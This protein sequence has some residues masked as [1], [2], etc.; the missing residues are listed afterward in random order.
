MAEPFDV[1]TGGDPGTVLAT[2]ASDGS[3]T[4]AGPVTSS[5]HVLV[6]QATDPTQIP[7]STI[8]Y[9]KSGQVWTLSGTGTAT[10]LGAGGTA[11]TFPLSG[12]GL[13]AASFNPDQG[14][15]P[16]N[17]VSGQA[18]FIRVYVPANTTITKLWCAVGTAGTWDASTTG[19]TIGIYT[20]AGVFVDKIA[21]S[22]S[23][24][25]TTGWVGGALSAGPITAQ[26]AARF[27]YLAPLVRGMTVAPVIAFLSSA[28]DTAGNLV[29]Y[30]G[31]PTG[32]TNRRTFYQSG[33]TALPGSFNPAS[34][35][36]V[37]TFTPL[38]AI[39]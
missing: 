32:V 7:G 33:L 29:W 1:R 23:L 14:M 22:D 34:A 28:N 4:V 6:D 16:Q 11:A 25:T 35:G 13:L 37:T 17:I 20:D 10:Q 21:T 19:S 24:W 26:T 30:S 12:Y 27:V 8:L 9:S 5:R 39:S 18:F 38:V 3:L 15:N 2:F 31:P 36:T